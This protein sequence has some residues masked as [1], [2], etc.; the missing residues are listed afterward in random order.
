MVDVYYNYNACI[1]SH[2]P[3]VKF[4]SLKPNYQICV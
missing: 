1:E 4:G 3:A 2:I